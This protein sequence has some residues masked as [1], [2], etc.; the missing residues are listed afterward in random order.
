MRA[1][2]ENRAPPAII[3]R[4]LRMVGHADHGIGGGFARWQVPEQDPHHRAKGLVVRMGGPA[5]GASPCDEAL[6]GS[7]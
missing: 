2:W 4:F 6:S 1:M 3:A 5:Q 7:Q